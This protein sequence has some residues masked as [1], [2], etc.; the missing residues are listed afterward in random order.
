MLKRVCS[1]SNHAGSRHGGVDLKF[2]ADME[3]LVVTYRESAEDRSCTIVCVT[4]VLRD[5]SFRR[6]RRFSSQIHTSSIE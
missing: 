3:T 4:V 2:L 5:S 1:S 6:V